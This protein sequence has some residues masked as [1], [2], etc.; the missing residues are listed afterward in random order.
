MSGASA[1]ADRL[2]S[3][4]ASP[5]DRF[6]MTVDSALLAGKLMPSCRCDRLAK[7]HARGLIRAERA[8]GIARLSVTPV[9]CFQ[10]K[11]GAMVARAT[12]WPGGEV[13]CMHSIH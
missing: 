12:C 11:H 10:V 8:R 1:C 13:S 5:Y 7:C 3:A 2:S 4:G 9:T 6:S